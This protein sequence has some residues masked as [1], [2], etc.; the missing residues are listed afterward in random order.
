MEGPLAEQVIP[1]ALKFQGARFVAAFP[2]DCN[3]LTKNHQVLF[4]L[5]GCLS[6]FTQQL[7]DGGLKKHRVWTITRHKARQHLPGIAQ[8]QALLSNV[9]VCINTIFLKSVN[10]FFAMLVRGYDESS[11]ALPEARSDDST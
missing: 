5:R 9:G 11:I 10:Q 1:Q 6:C 8:G 4:L 7:A 3:H 2:Q